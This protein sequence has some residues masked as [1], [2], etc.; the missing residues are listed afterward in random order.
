MRNVGGINKVVLRISIS[1]SCQ[2]AGFHVANRA[3]YMSADV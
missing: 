3:G 2:F 1:F